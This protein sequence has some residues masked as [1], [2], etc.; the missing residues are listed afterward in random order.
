MKKTIIVIFGVLIAF[1]ALFVVMRGGTA[2]QSEPR[3]KLEVSLKEGSDAFNAGSY[4]KAVVSWKEGLDLAK[5][6]GNLEYQTALNVSL[7]SAYSYLF[8]Y[9]EALP[10]FQKG[11]EL[12]KLRDDDSNE[13]A[14][15]NGLAAICTTT[16]E[17]EKAID[18]FKEAIALFKRLG[19]DQNAAMLT[20]NLGET[21]RMMGDYQESL[22]CFEETLSITE[23]LKDPVAGGRTQCSIGLI[24]YNLGQ[25]ERAIYEYQ[26]ALKIGQHR[27]DAA[28]QAEALGGLG[29]TYA[30]MGGQDEL[31]LSSLE[32]A[33]EASKKTN[34]V[35]AQG[36]TA[37]SLGMF[38]YQK[39]KYEMALAT[40]QRALQ[41][42]TKAN[43]V[44]AQMGCLSNIGQTYVKLNDP[45]HALGF[46]DRAQKIA[47]K[48]GDTLEKSRV[49]NNRGL[50][51]LHLGRFAEAES[52][53]S[54]S[55]QLFDH[56]RT[57][58][59]TSEQR[60]ALVGTLPYVHE[61]LAA[62]ELELGNQQAAFEAVERSRSKSLIDLLATRN[63]SKGD[64]FKKSDELEKLD[65]KLTSLGRI[66]DPRILAKVEEQ[67][68]ELVQEIQ[69]KDPELGALVSVQSVGLPEIQSAIDP[70]A[71]LIEFFHP[72][73]FVVNGVEKDDLWIFVLKDGQLTF[74]RSPVPEDEFNESLSEFAEAASTPE[75]SEAALKVM[76][77]KIYDWL[78]QPV[79]PFLNAETL[80]IVPWGAGFHIPYAALWH[81]VGKGGA[82]LGEE[83]R[84]AIVPSGNALRF[85]LKHRS[86]AHS[87]ILAF[88]NPTTGF[89]P[90]PGAEME[91]AEVA[92]LFP[93]NAVLLRGD[94]TET[95]I[96][97]DLGHPD[98]IHFATHGLFNPDA[99]YLSKVLLAADQ[100][101]D[102]NLEVHELFGLDWTGVSLVTLSACSTGKAR[103]N[104]GNDIV[105]LTQGFFFAGAPTVLASLWDVNDE[106]TRRLMVDYY[107]ALIAGNSK[108]EALR[109]AQARLR[110]DRQFSHPAYWAA[111]TLFGDWK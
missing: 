18:Y 7:G 88:G 76:S 65:N 39:G 89:D 104:P 25:Y 90:L 35:K 33:L 36:N 108:A 83:H 27:N 75:V 64:R 67:R 1:A 32:Q 103:L 46:L 81:S 29:S 22:K 20:Y 107:Q 62:V 110:N 2:L 61:A 21:Y 12:S 95:R 54:R 93:S 86:D 98:V 34:D 23:K 28:L 74:V 73:P 55:A 5:E 80:I 85:L 105:G 84:I 26:A 77:Q 68:L 49:L 44:L 100:Q 57:E 42:D 82:Y 102:G 50:V 17:Y 79:E 4:Q 51:L 96:K 71:T 66:E 53:L 99:P 30:V 60:A 70:G 37:V 94:A 41:L 56:I 16:G 24:Y 111:F 106:A 72:F 78:F 101:N 63:F 11:L 43:D 97:G 13:A 40:F 109:I 3:K 47:D 6:Q 52:S 31:A 87:K 10:Y 45:D 48:L 9:D 15:L 14:A 59:K 19:Q 8:K 38:Q 91:A 69:E 92:N 58:M